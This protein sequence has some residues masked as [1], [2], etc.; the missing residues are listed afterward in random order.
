M[1][2]HS[3]PRYVGHLITLDLMTTLQNTQSHDDIQSVSRH[4]QSHDDIYAVHDIIFTIIIH[5]SHLSFVIF[6]PLDLPFYI[7]SY[8]FN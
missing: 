1:E 8:A 7:L 2:K 5:S 4:T 3:I 6:S